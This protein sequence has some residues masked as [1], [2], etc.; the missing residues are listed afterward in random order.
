[1]HFDHLV[2]AAVAAHAAHARRQVRRVIKINVV[3]K[4]MNLHPRHR[5]ARWRSSAAPA[6]AAGCPSSPA[7]GSSCRCCRRNRR[8]RRLINGG[9][10]VVTIQ[11]QLPRVQLVAVGDRL[12]R[13]VSCI[14]HRRIRVIG[15]GGDANHRAN[16]TTRP[17]T[18][19]IMSDDFGKITAISSVVSPD[20]RIFGR[21]LRLLVGANNISTITAS[22]RNWSK[23]SCL[24][25]NE[26]RSEEPSGTSRFARS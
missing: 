5:L 17:A 14:D 23:N 15:V 8:E 19:K 11:P 12:H 24:T 13:L 16:P 26:S 4:A 18:F 22:V 6:P 2:D 20:L 7:C 3:G 21:T 9:V 1:M 25:G 10:A